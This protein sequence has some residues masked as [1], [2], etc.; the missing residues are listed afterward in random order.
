M[1]NP[2]FNIQYGL[3]VITTQNGDRDNGCISNTVAQVTAQPNRISVA[4]NKGNFTTELIQHSGRF[5]ASILS[6][7][8]D[9]ELFKHFGF[10]SGRTVD[11]FAD[12]TDCRRVNNGTFAITRGTNAF[13][14]AEVEQTIDLG[15]HMLFIGLVTEMETLSD[16]P[17]ATYN[18]YQANIK[19]KPQPVGQT[20]E[21]KTIWRCSICGYEYVG[22]ELPDDFICPICKHPASDFVKVSAE[23]EASVANK[24]AGTKTEKNLEAAF[25]GESMARNKYT[26]YASVAKKNGYEQIAALFLKTA[27]NEKEHAKLWFKHLG[28]VGTTAENLLHAA[29]G[30]NYEWTDMYETFAR[31]ADEEGFHELAEQ[32]RGVAAIEKRHEERYRALLH[33]VETAEVFQKS[34]V[35]V[36]ECRNCGHIVVGTTAPDVCPVCSHPQAYFE[37][38]AENY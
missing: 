27:E 26:Y 25:A 5:T 31:E 22:E 10:Q 18:Y 29:E 30:E 15:T 36:W 24:Y 28:G 6:E 23:A 32:F 34:G 4:L 37:I 38:N 9:F 20:V 1:S 14:S 7:A 13:I 3:F 17:S 35:S 11:K 12:F 19:P 33:N 2:L 21:G 16:I 8:A